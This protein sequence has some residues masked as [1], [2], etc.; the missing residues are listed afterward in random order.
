MKRVI[1]EISLLRQLTRRESSPHVVQ[2]YEV[3]VDGKFQEGQTVVLFLVMERMKFDLREVLEN[4]Q[5]H[6]LN[7]EKLVKIQYQLLCALSHLSELDILHRDIKPA[8]ILLDA[9]YN[10]KIA[11]LGLARHYPTKIKEK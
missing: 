4:P 11:D 3:I 1:R 7:E 5:K 8:N 9:D 10:V 6:S 2:L